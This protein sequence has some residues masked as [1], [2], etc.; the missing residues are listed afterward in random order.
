MNDFSAWMQE[1][2]DDY[3]RQLESLVNI[4]SGSYHKAGVSKVLDWVAGYL[5]GLG[6]EV[7]RLQDGGRL[8]C[9][10]ATVHPGASRERSALLLGHCD[11]VFPEGEAQRRPFRVD[12]P[13]A[14]GPGVADMKAGVLMNAY[15]LQAWQA[16]GD[17]GTTLSAL[18]TCD[19]EIGSPQSGAFIEATCRQHRYAFNSEPGRPNGN[20]V[21]G[22]KGGVFFDVQVQGKAAHAGANFYSGISAIS[23]LAKKIQSMEQLIDP[24]EGI[25]LNVGLIRG[26]LSV[27]TVAPSAV[28]G[29]DLRIHTM[30][31]RE[32]CLSEVARI[33]A[34]S[35]QGETAS[36][37]VRGEFK[38]F[39]QSEGSRLLAE[40]YL[41]ISVTEGI[42]VKGEV[43]GGCSDSGIAAECGCDVICAVG[44]SGG[45][46]HT[47][48]E[49]VRLDSVV[50]KATVLFRTLKTLGA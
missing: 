45:G 5:D 1:R 40:K 47:P 22:R 24:D 3:V 39:V 49:Y 10:R 48:E 18:F 42:A 11:T 31:Q 15:L 23:A 33:C 43:T 44:P 46:F 30:A 20:V 28:A 36:W 50:G 26:G 13:V 2:F 17:K 37:S 14:Y 32:R 38:P 9:V 16:M 8:V 19:E 6:I 12:G 4:D 41:E 34:T 21:V 29:V 7:Q 27:N 25:T 35:L